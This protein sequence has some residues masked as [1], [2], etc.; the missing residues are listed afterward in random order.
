MNEKNLTNKIKENC[1]KCF[2]EYQNNCI[3]CL[4]DLSKYNFKRFYCKHQ[5]HKECIKSW[6]EKSKRCPICNCKIIYEEDFSIYNYIIGI[7]KI[8]IWELISSFECEDD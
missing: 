6:L 7:I 4:S 3:I 8:I 2:D 5:F 1:L